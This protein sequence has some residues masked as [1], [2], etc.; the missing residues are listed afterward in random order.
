MAPSANNAQKIDA[1]TNDG[2]YGKKFL[3]M[4]FILKRLR[5]GVHELPLYRIYTNAHDFMYL[6]NAYFLSLI[7][8]QPSRKT[9][10]PLPHQVQQPHSASR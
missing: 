5:P 4:L 3:S 10:K 8:Q 2:S 6:G 9:R 7:A 1:A